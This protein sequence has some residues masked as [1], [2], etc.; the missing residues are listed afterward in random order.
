[1]ARAK[2]YATVD[3]SGTVTNVVMW[4][5]DSGWSPEPGETAVECSPDVAIGWTYAGRS[6]VPASVAAPSAAPAEIPLWALRAAIKEA[7]AF[8][9]IDAFVEQHKDDMPALWEAWNMGNTVSVN[10]I[11]VASFAPQFGI[12][13]AARDALMRKASAISAGA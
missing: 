6:F 12:D 7:N 2:R 8:A 13:A 4:D 1:M 3:E 5:G 10:S 11:L 9:A